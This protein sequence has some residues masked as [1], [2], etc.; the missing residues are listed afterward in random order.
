VDLDPGRNDLTNSVANLSLVG[1]AMEG[2]KRRERKQKK[3]KKKNIVGNLVGECTLVVKFSNIYYR[4]ESCF[5]E[6]I[7]FECSEVIH[8]YILFVFISES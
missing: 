7:D 8:L 3:K 6:I 4:I 2:E 5:G 1:G